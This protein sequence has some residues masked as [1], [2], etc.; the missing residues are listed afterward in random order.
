MFK[1]LSG[2]ELQSIAMVGVGAGLAGTINTQIERMLPGWGVPGT[3]TNAAAGLILYMVLGKMQ[4]G[5]LQ[6]V[7]YGYA[8]QSVGSFIGQA[9]GTMLPQ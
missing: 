7:A 6:Q 9:I 8:V 4:R 2:K 5:M 3:A 1:M